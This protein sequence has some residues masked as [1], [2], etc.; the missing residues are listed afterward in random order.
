MENRKLPTILDLTE[1]LELSYKND[2]LNL[3]LSQQPPQTWIKRHPYIKDYNYLPIDKIEHLLRKIFKQ[4]R[5]EVLKTA[6]LFNA[7]EVHV[8][9]H[10]LHPVTNEWNYH[11]GV[12]ACELQTKKDSGN[13]NLDL[14]NINKGAVIMAL[15]IAK[16]TAIK[17]ACDMF[18]SLF[19]ANL[20]RR[21]V[22]EF[23]PDAETLNFIKSNKEKL[24]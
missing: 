4:Y 14:S 6:Q 18:G 10:Y 16:T 7:I 15:P 23:K 17:D 19:G 1:D 3:L 12:G 21:D 11:D 8:R 22:V 2:A 20:N 9:V 5:I 13:L 24:A